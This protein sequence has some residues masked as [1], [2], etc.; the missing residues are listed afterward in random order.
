MHQALRGAAGLN[1]HD[2]TV[3]DRYLERLPF[4]VGGTAGGNTPCVEIQ[5]GDQ[6]LIIDA[7]SGLRLLGLDL[8]RR[9]FDQGHRQADILIT[10]THWDHIHGFPFFR[11]AF[12]PHNC[13]TFYSPF[14][15]LAERL[16]AQQQDSFF[17]VS[18]SYMSAKLE[19]RFIAE[20]DWHQVGRFRVYPMRLSHPGVTYGY[21]VEDGV[22][23]LVL[24]TDSEYKQVDPASTEN[25]VRFFKEADLLIFDAQYTL[26]EALDRLDWGHSTAVMGAELAR[27]AGVKRLALSHHDPVRNDDK[28][29][30]AKEQAEAYL[31]RCSSHAVAEVLIAYEGLSL[32]I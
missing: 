9:G 2:P 22:S 29:W 16:A 4:S 10:H 8:L 20:N 6:L 17:P 11:P 23:S 26:A 24:A 18:M 1:L 19:F 31:L 14:E 5:S 15:D 21:R 7:G 12:V 28:I 25:Y 27:R 32:E 30:A 3:L 13:F